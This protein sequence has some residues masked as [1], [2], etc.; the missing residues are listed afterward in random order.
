MDK[1]KFEE[2]FITNAPLTVFQTCTDFVNYK[3][4][5]KFRIIHT[6]SLAVHLTIVLRGSGARKTTKVSILSG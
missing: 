6:S 3:Y 2:V 5:F 4:F 1:L